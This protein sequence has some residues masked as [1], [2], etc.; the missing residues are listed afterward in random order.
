MEFTVSYNEAIQRCMMLTSFEGKN[1]TDGEGESLFSETVITTQDRP[2]ITDYLNCGAM[3]IEESIA[4]LVLSSSY[5]GDTDGQVWSLQL[6]LSDRWNGNR[7]DFTQYLQEALVSFALSKWYDLKWP[8]KV[9]KYVTLWEESLNRIVSNAFRRSQPVKKPNKA[10][11]P[12]IT[13]V[14]S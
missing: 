14:N 11:E 8:D 2:L 9:A 4:R 6:R 12:T 5:S 3:I 13:I 7:T 10:A 1:H